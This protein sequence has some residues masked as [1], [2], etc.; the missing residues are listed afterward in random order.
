MG[1]R[2]R[3]FCLAATN[4]LLATSVK[5]LAL[6]SSICEALLNKMLVNIVA[7]TTKIIA[8]AIQNAF[9]AFSENGQLQDEKTINSDPCSRFC[10]R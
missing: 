5:I 8:S 7:E 1:D 6:A 3:R 9:S 2:E 10:Q 4:F